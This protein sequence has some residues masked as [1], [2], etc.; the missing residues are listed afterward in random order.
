M[1]RKVYDVVVDGQTFTVEVIDENGGVRV[2]VDGQ[3]V[4]C[5]PI[6]GQHLYVVHVD[7]RRHEAAVQ[8]VTAERYHV[9]VG[10]HQLEVAVAEHG[11]RRAS[12]SPL[13]AIHP[14]TTTVTAP[15]PGLVVAVTVAPGDTVR[16][17][18]TVAVLEAM[19]MENDLVAPRDG[20]VADVPVR[21]GQSVNMGQ[22]LVIL[23]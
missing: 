17:G 6:D 8:R 16:R 9:A 23:E 12:P 18:Q 2:V 11:G 4:A 1:G 14:T 22:P 10:D 15:M 7:D 20:R 13:A 19:K 5:E 3:P 21:P